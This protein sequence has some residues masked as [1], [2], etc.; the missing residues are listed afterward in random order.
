[1]N[2]F[3]PSNKINF[4]QAIQELE[5]VVSN[6]ENCDLKLDAL[7]GHYQKGK[8]LLSNCRKKL[9]HAELKIK[10]TTNDVQIDN[11]NDS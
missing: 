9:N 6:M 8:E 11:Q 5:K 2:S 10:E 7:V 1:V 4:E 3:D